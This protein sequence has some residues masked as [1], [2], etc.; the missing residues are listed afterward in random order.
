MVCGCREVAP[1]LLGFQQ[2]Q[3]IDCRGPACRKVRRQTDDRHDQSSDACIGRD[4][5][6][7][8]MKAHAL[9][10]GVTAL[11][12]GE[13]RVQVRP[14]ERDDAKPAKYTISLSEVRD[15]TAMERANA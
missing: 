14:F 4:I 7:G 11:S 10:A 2:L 1:S 5:E 12:A 13:Y 8:Y 9:K 6:R 3:R 15:L